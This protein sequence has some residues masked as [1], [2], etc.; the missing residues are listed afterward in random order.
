MFMQCAAAAAAAAAGASQAAE[1]VAALANSYGRSSNAASASAYVEVGGGDNRIVASVYGPRRLPASSTSQ[2]GAA[3]GSW[4]RVDVRYAPFA[5]ARGD[6]AAPASMEAEISCRVR[7]VLS[8]SVLPE[9]LGAGL[10]VEVHVLV[11]NS[12]GGDLPLSI[13]CASLALAHAGVPMKDIVAAAQVV[14]A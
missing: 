2:P 7:E 6:P 12:G 11:I 10:G 4:L 9:Q 13:I 14:R 3:A 8:A 1:V 5:M